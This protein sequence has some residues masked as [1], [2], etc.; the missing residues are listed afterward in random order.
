MSIQLILELYHST[1]GKLPGDLKAGKYQSRFSNRLS[2]RIIMKSFINVLLFV[3]V[4]A[5]RIIGIFFTGLVLLLGDFL[6]ALILLIVLVVSW[7][8]SWIGGIIFAAATVAYLIGKDH[9]EAIIYI[10]LIFI[11]VLYLLGWI[12]RKEITSAQ[13]EFWWGEEQN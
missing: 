1:F 3:L 4:W 9:W 13:E 10:P 6:P 8:W 2:F 5:P 11:S 12:L 7:K